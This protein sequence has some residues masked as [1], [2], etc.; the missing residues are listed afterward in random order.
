MYAY[1]YVYIDMYVLYVICSIHWRR[2]GICFYIHCPV[3]QNP[4]WIHPRIDLVLQAW[5][6]NQALVCSCQATC[7]QYSPTCVCICMYMQHKLTCSAEWWKKSANVGLLGKVPEP[8]WYDFSPMISIF[9]LNHRPVRDTFVGFDWGGLGLCWNLNIFYFVFEP[10]PIVKPAEKS[11]IA[12]ATFPII[13]WREHYAE[14]RRLAPVI[15]KTA[16]LI[17]FSNQP[18]DTRVRPLKFQLLLV[19]SAFLLPL[20]LAVKLRCS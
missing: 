15:V 7:S 2:D 9:F 10:S 12:T 4:H 1:I 8:I 13:D 11:G 20:S 14:C 16:V 3:L 17:M 19:Y 18:S 6:I 5:R